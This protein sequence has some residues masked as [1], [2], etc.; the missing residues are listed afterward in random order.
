MRSVNEEEQGLLAQRDDDYRRIQETHVSN[1]QIIR[2]REQGIQE[3]EAAMLDINDM[4]HDL[5]NIVIEQGV[6]IGMS[7]VQSTERERER[8]R[9]Q[10]AQSTERAQSAQSMR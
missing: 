8:E 7:T 6:M 10:S 3:I 5:K 1:D 4:F 9:A 2:E